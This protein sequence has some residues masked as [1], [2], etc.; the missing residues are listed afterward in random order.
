MQIVLAHSN[1]KYTNKLKNG[2]LKK[3]LKNVQVFDDGFKALAYIIQNYSELIIVEEDLP[4]LS[5]ED[6]QNA[7]IFKGIKSKLLIL[8]NNKQDFHKIE[9]TLSQ[10]YTIS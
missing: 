8:K 1:K 2:I 10:N 3:H 4:N 7:L 5:A 6:I 9:F